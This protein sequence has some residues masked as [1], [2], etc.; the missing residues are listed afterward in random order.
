MGDLNGAG[1]QANC[2]PVNLNW[3]C[4]GG[5]HPCLPDASIFFLFSFFDNF[6]YCFLTIRPALSKAMAGAASLQKWKLIRCQ[7]NHLVNH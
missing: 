7:S 5:H 3:D 6:F 2:L 1:I 4:P